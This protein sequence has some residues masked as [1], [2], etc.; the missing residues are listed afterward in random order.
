MY[1][2]VTRS[3]HSNNLLPWPFSFP[4][5]ATRSGRTD[6]FLPR[7][8]CNRLDPSGVSDQVTSRSRARCRRQRFLDTKAVREASRLRMHPIAQPC[9]VGGLT[10]GYPDCSTFAY[11]LCT[12]D[13]GL[14]MRSI[15][16]EGTSRY[17]KLTLCNTPSLTP[18]RLPNSIAKK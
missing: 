17:G 14:Y 7:E 9:G 1:C 2:F 13:V 11:Q 6:P 4:A 8:L 18:N 12:Q 15:M 3:H 10:R 16:E 5:S